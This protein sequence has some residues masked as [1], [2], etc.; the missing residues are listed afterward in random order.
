MFEPF[1]LGW[2]KFGWVD[3]WPLWEGIYTEGYMMYIVSDSDYTLY[4]VQDFDYRLYV[5]QYL[6]HV[7]K[8]IFVL[9]SIMYIQ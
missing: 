2:A 1:L 5:M 3:Y 4:F 6:H 7:K 8:I 9:C